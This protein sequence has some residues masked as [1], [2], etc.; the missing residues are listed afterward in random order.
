[1]DVTIAGFADQHGLP[2][3][4]FSDFAVMA[5]QSLPD[6]GVISEDAKDIPQKHVQKLIE[7]VTEGCRETAA[8]MS[9]DRSENDAHCDD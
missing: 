6:A 5:K 8:R 7:V 4:M 2:A 9:K 1:M 3:S